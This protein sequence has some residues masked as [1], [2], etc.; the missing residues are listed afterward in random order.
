MTLSVI[1]LGAPGAGKG[2]QAAILARRFGFVPVNSGGLLR[3]EA[4]NGTAA[5]RTV[6]GYMRRGELVPDAIV[7]DVVARRIRQR[8]GQRLVIEGYPKTAAQAEVVTRILA[9]V[10]SPA[11]LAV[12]FVV[13]RDTLRRRLF[14]RSEQG[15]R[16][17]DLPDTIA[18]RLDAL[19]S[20]PSGTGAG[21]NA[22]QA[23]RREG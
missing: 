21:A 10:G 12:N 5:G 11:R 3:D 9:A 18:R 2:T 19:G 6:A 17:D 8:A 13:D 22:A 16:D 20:T 14:A 1:F 7:T 15:G 4:A 23:V